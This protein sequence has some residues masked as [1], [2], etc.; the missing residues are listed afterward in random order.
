[1]S[2]YHRIVLACI[3]TFVSLTLLQGCEEEK[4][5]KYRV[6]M[7]S[8]LIMLFPNADHKETTIDFTHEI[9]NDTGGQTPVKVTFN[10]LNAS[11]V[12]LTVQL[13]YDSQKDNGPLP[14]K[15]DKKQNREEKYRQS[16]TKLQGSSYYAKVNSEGVVTELY[17]VDEAIQRILDGKLSGMFGGDQITMLLNESCLKDY[18]L[19]GLSTRFAKSWKSKGK[20]ASSGLTVVPSSKTVS[21]SRNFKMEGKQKGTDGESVSLVT[22]KISKSDAGLD[23]SKK[24]SSSSSLSITAFK[25][26]GKITHSLDSKRLVS[27]QETVTADVKAG[28]VRRGNKNKNNKRF[29]YQIK[30]NIT[31]IDG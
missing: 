18:A 21:T 16:F 30:K 22:Y 1:M 23:K 8:D 25:G 7:V 15:K 19:L 4:V 14:P 11:M 10:S 27:W 28:S 6:N 2:K 9:L 20:W 29:Y 12:S 3:L 24:K 13:S 5:K 31:P 17:D 26:S